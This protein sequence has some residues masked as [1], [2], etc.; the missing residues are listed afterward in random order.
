MIPADYDLNAVF[1]ALA[2]V[3]DGTPTGESFS[4]SGE[5]FSAYSEVPGQVSAPAVILELD[6]LDWDMTMGAGEDEF[7]GTLTLLLDYQDGRGAQRR[8]RSMLSRNGAA[9]RLKA[10]LAAEQT[11]GGLVSYV[12]MV[13]LR[14]FGVIPFG[15]VD[16][17]GAEIELE[18]VS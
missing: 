5:T 7:S 9:G 14:R 17:L 3:F 15:G 12:H 18:I 2:E 1:D 13:R 11:L 8:M 6:T 16:Y 4:G 10:A